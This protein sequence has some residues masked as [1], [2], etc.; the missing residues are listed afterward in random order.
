MRRARRRQRGE[1]DHVEVPL[2][3]F[4]FHTLHY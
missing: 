2:E 4:A 3:H 1:H